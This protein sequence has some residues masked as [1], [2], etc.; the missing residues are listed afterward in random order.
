MGIAAAVTV[1]TVAALWWFVRVEVAEYHTRPG[2]RLTVSLSDGSTVRL[3][4]D[5]RL[6]VRLSRSGRDIQ[7]LDGE[8]LFHAAK[9]PRR[10]FRVHCADS[11]IRALGTSFNV[12][13]RQ[14]VTTITVIDGLVEVAPKAVAVDQA[15]NAVAA[16]QKPFRLKPREQANIAEDGRLQETQVVDTTPVVAWTQQSLRFSGKPLEE[17]IEQFNQYNSIHM[18]LESPALASVQ[19]SGVFSSA[20]IESFI[21][22]L[23]KTEDVKIVRGDAEVRIVGR[24]NE[25]SASL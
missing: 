1:V 2:D 4:T 10:P 20:D 19:I 11:E 17:V 24:S 14:K 13:R 23:E 12:Y 5:T 7:L 18:S 15:S 8:A 25:A 9:D 6:R 16:L 22:Y 3:N 21:Q